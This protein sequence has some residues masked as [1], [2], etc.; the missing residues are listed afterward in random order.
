MMCELLSETFKLNEYSIYSQTIHKFYTT[1]TKIS[2]NIKTSR[3]RYNFFITL[4][5]L[6][7]E[8]LRWRLFR[9]F[10]SIFFPN[11]GKVSDVG[12][13]DVA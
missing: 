2:V 3:E 10:M 9:T 4:F 8:T 1:F 13:M 11:Y 7:K 6:L 5:S 12:N